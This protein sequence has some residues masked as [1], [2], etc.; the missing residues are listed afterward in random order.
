MR[1]LNN[2]KQSVR[3]CRESFRRWSTEPRIW[4]V[5]F[6]II[7]F[8]WTQVEKVRFYC[9]EQGLSVSNWLFPFLFTSNAMG[10]I[11][12]YL[13]VL[14]IFYLSLHGSRNFG[15]GIALTIVLLH[16]AENKVSAVFAS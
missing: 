2:W 13:G 11:F 3:V 9:A 8:E 16:M 15:V 14:L 4:S 6:F 1:N 10:L 5:L 7:L 12:F